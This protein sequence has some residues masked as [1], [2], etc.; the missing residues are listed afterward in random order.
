MIFR[1]LAFVLTAPLLVAT[2][3]CARPLPEEGA[4]SVDAEKVTVTGAYHPV[5]VDGVERMT[6]E[7]ATLILH[8]QTGQASVP[9]PPNAD[10]DQKNKGWALVTEGDGDDDHSRTLTFTQENSLE[11]FT[12]SVP[13]APGQVTYGSLGGRDG[14]DVLIFAYGTTE[15]SYWGW[16]T[17][18]KKAAAQ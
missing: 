7:N 6:I 4:I 8:G 3:A 2:V 10:P 16:A 5:K 15:K 18:T 1:R 9:L 14:H 12:I 17:I 11:D 13:A